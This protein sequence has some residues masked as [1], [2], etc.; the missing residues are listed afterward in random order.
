[1]WQ[2]TGRVTRPNVKIFNSTAAAPYPP[3]PVGQKADQTFIL[4]ISNTQ[5]AS[6]IWALNGT[7]EMKSIADGTGE[8]ILFKPHPYRMNNLTIT[9][10][11]GTW[12]DLIFQIIQVPQPSHPIHKHGDKMF[13]IG[14]GN[15]TFNWNLFCVM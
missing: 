4:T 13:L 15:G 2:A 7:A 1:M 3:Y 6:Y 14:A 11:N 12:I 5:D 8:P 10:L 9:T